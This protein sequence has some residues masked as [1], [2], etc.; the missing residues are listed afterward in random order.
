MAEQDEQFARK[1]TGAIPRE[2]LEH[3]R[4]LLHGQEIPTLE[5]KLAEIPLLREI[6]EELAEIRRVMR[7]L[8]HWDLTV[9][10][11]VEGALPDGLRSLQSELRQAIRRIQMIEQG[12]LS[13]QNHDM[14][15]F[16]GVFN[17]MVIRLGNRFRELRAREE[18]LCRMTANLQNEVD[19]RDS[20]V[21]ALQ[22]S[23]SRFRY[24]ADH[25][26]LTGVLNRRSFVER[27]V[28]E[29][30]LAIS[31]GVFC[32]LAIMDIDHFKLFNDRYGHLA[33]DAALRHTVQ[34]VSSGLR[35]MDF[36]GR[37]GGEEFVFFFTGADLARGHAIC[38]RVRKSL[39]AAP[40]RLETEEV[41]ITASFGVTQSRLEEFSVPPEGPNFSLD[42]T[43]VIRLLVDKAD[44]ALYRA[45]NNGRNQVVSFSEKFSPRE[46]LHAGEFSDGKTGVEGPAPEPEKMEYFAEQQ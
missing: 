12:D 21:Q 28:Y 20:T 38:E 40:L 5:G 1:R 18:S 23:E 14:G 7:A 43:E 4:M 3:I 39:A 22:K 26:P 42:N 36:M 41:F 2:S 45:K 11:A 27:A 30:Q 29:L 8:A 15:E 46:E 24:L 34:A 32:C 37:Y 25:D 13:P 10:C 35:K 44:R 9:E 16:S 6:H 19:E 31:K 33:G 17:N